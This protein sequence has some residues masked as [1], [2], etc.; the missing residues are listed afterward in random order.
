MSES[1]S[2]NERPDL[3]NR[4]AQLM[5]DAMPLG[6][7]LWD[8]NYTIINSNK[9][10]MVLFGA[11]NK[12]KLEENF[13]DYSPIYQSEEKRSDEQLHLSVEE[14]F[15][16]GQ[17]IFEW[18]FKAQNG[19][20]IPAEVTMVRIKD[21][22]SYVVAGYVRDLREHKQMMQEIEHKNKLLHVVNG[23]AANILQSRMDSLGRKIQ[24]SLC[25][26][27]ESVNADRVYIWKNYMRD[28]QLYC[29][30]IYEWSGRAE[31]QR[32]NELAVETLYS[33][34]IP[35]WEIKLSQGQC[36]NGIIR[37]MSKNE[38]EALMP[39]GIKS[40]LVVPI[41]LKNHF[42]G[43]VG[44]D[45]CHSE[46]VFS[47][48]DEIILRS[49]SELIGG[50]LFRACLETEVDKIFY[51]PLTGI[52]NRRFFDENVTQLLQTLSHT[53]GLLTM[54]MID[55]DHFKQYNDQYGHL[56]GD[57]CLKVIAELLQQCITKDDN[58]VVRYGGEEFV[59][60]LPNTD[61]SG[62][63]IM[64]QKV[65]AEVRE[66]NIV[67]KVDNVLDCVTV[68]IGV[69]TGKVEPTHCVSDFVKRADEMMYAAKRCGRNQ[70]VAGYMG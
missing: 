12:R 17:S 52:Y 50:A 46:R 26:L 3:A 7:V 67:H 40:L 33:E 4:Y 43:F 25:H 8:E 36:V 39:Q 35:E 6:V 1:N 23:I 9:A 53:G 63:H 37:F 24:E 41:F 2:T 56:E 15:A 48:S 22:N 42:W 29:S 30:Q 18:M 11:N 5:L 14:A 69:T 62:A 54:M 32:H 45:D 44:F 28:N 47:E 21:G 49:A 38:Q 58:Y 19:T 13:N 55:I 70:S 68:S 34:F 27:A 60:I 65:L 51:D 10:A 66:R 61:S 64:A 31:S 20:E 16:Q 59:A 57:K